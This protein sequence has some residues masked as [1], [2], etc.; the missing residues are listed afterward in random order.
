MANFIST[1]RKYWSIDTAVGITSDTVTTITLNVGTTGVTG[2]YTF[3]STAS[4][5]V[6]GGGNYPHS[7]KRDDNNGGI[8]LMPCQQELKE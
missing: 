2:I 5:A 6:I 4:G 8:L 3:T 1:V 7:W